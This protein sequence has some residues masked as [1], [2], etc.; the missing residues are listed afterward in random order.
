M[1]NPA[2]PPEPHTMLFV[3]TV[4]LPQTM[5]EPHTML[6]PVGNWRLTWLVDVL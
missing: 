1:L 2:L 4:L 5:L 6:L 3:K